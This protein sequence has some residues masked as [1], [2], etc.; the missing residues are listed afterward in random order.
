MP[1]I[2]TV[3]VLGLSLT[4][5]TLSTTPFRRLVNCQSFGFCLLSVVCSRQD[6][7][8]NR[9]TVLGLGVE[10]RTFLERAEMNKVSAF[11]SSFT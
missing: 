8:E 7:A 3:P 1:E 6:R 11:L 5:A 9:G 2:H 4:L 10:G